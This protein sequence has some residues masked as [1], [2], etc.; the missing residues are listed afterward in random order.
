M[1]VLLLLGYFKKCLLCALGSGLQMWESEDISLPA[2]LPPLSYPR[3]R[4]MK[5]FIKNK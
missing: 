2:S 3:T 1:I 4:Q 5:V